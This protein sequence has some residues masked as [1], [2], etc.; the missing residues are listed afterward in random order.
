MRPGILI[1]AHQA[2]QRTQIWRL[3]FCGNRGVR[4]VQIVNHRVSLV[5]DCD[6]RDTTCG[7]AANFLLSTAWRRLTFFRKL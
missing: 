4:S 2:L 5:Y 1:V 3:L 6:R 7:S